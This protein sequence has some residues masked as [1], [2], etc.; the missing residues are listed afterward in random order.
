MAITYGIA[1]YDKVV[2]GQGRLTIPLTDVISLANDALAAVLFGLR[3]DL[4]L[5][6]PGTRYSM[7]NSIFYVGECAGCMSHFRID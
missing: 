7:A 5:V 2:M 3:Q 4:D 6:N 1:F